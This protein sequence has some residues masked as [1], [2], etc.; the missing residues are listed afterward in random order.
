MILGAFKLHKGDKMKKEK[1]VREMNV[2]VV[3]RGGKYS[4]GHVDQLYKV[5]SNEVSGEWRGATKT[6]VERLRRQLLK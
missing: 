1:L 6:T 5:N 4:L 2:R 3:E